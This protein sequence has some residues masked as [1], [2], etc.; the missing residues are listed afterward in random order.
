KRDTTVPVDVFGNVGSFHAG[1]TGMGTPVRSNFPALAGFA[2]LV[3]NHALVLSP[4]QQTWL[5]PPFASMHL[6]S[7]VLV[8]H[9][10]PVHVALHAEPPHWSSCTGTPTEGSPAWGLH[11]LGPASEAAPEVS[12]RWI[13]SEPANCDVALSG[14]QSRL[15]LYV[16]SPA[17]WAT[18]TVPSTVH[19]LS[20]FGPDVHAPLL[21]RGHTSPAVVRN[22]SE[23][24]STVRVTSPVCRFVV[25]VTSFWKRL[26]TQTGTLAARSGRGGPKTSVLIEFT[27]VGPVMVQTGVAVV[28]QPLRQSFRFEPPTT[29]K[30]CD[31]PVHPLSR[32]VPLLATVTVAMLPPPAGFAGHGGTPPQA[33]PVHFAHRRTSVSGSFFGLPSLSAT[34][35]SRFTP[36]LVC[37]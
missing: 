23:K 30:L 11:G 5:S 31:V 36:G 14:G 15:T 3:G 8:L 32:S 18:V 26:V 33:C 6:L 16:L 34:T 24:R 25:P 29:G 13:G 17:A 2:V 20:A 28:S 35:R 1:L 10:S 37:F 22:T 27:P 19:D 12:G 21:Q 4:T 9:A 7:D